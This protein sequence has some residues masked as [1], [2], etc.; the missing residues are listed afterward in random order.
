MDANMQVREV[1]LQVLHIFGPR[2]LVDARRCGLLQSE[3][4]RPQNVDV[5]VMQKRRQLALP[6]PDDG[7]SYAGLRLC[8][9]LPALRP[10][11]ALQIRILLGPAPSLHGLRSG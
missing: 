8:D 1:R 3:E 4:T 6:V 9:E 5:E 10:D 11:R 2:H 7:F